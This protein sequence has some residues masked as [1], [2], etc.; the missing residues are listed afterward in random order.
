MVAME[1]GGAGCQIRIPTNKTTKIGKITESPPYNKN[2]NL[3]FEKH[4]GIQCLK[5]YQ[6]L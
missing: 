2:F 5:N 6:F 3:I 4:D 1:Q